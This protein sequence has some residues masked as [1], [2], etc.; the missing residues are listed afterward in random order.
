M[1]DSERYGISFSS[2]QVRAFGL[3]EKAALAWLLAQGWRRF[4]LMNY[5]DEHEKQPGK[6]DFTALDRQIRQITAIGGSIT[7]CLG[8]KQP[9]WPE[10]HWPGWA[11]ESAAEVRDRALLM[12][13][14]KVVEHYKDNP[15][16]VSYQLENEALLKGFGKNIAIS[17]KRLRQEFQL[18]R[19]LDPSRP[20]IMSTS[21]GWG[22]PLRRPLP[23]IVGFSCYFRLW[24]HGRYHTT[25]Q[26]PWL[27]RLRK[28]AVQLLLRR[29]VFIHELQCEPWG[30]RAIW[31]MDTPEQDKSMNTDQIT[32]NIST[33]RSICHGPIDLWGAEWWYWRH[34]Q[35]DDTIWNAVE[36]SLALPIDEQRWKP[37]Q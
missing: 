25:I 37:V 19:R 12:Y 18:V 35:G 4:R 7:L 27:H 29:P 36:T 26:S 16:I 1:I 30:P 23:D 15:A 11:W 10:Y 22:I 9:R 5:W 6:Y 14:Q 33:V 21:N 31:E 24:S 3:D 20:I 2:K 32:H 8:I 34:A 28:Y 17:R 13:L